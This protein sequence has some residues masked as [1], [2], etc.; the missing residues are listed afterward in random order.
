MQTAKPA[1]PKRALTREIAELFPVQ[2]EWTEEAYLNLPETN[3]L[4]EL[5]D[6]KLELLAMPTDAHQRVVGQLFFLLTLF[7]RQHALGV[8]RVAP[9]RVRL[10]PGRYR[11]P[12]LVFMGAAH[13]D[14]MTNEFWGVP[15]LAIEVH[16]PDSRG[17][18]RQVQHGEYGRAGIAE[19]WM[20]DLE[21]KTIEVYGLQAGDYQLQG[22]HGLGD[23]L[24]SPGLPGLQLS[25]TDAFAD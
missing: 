12:D 23:T 22:V 20:V 21:T 19:Y 18:D 17:R 3:R 14:R 5:A 11:E 6:G 15:D 25:V 13:A 24:T 7:L 10:A 1:P 8:L 2:G 9:L 16:S 4:V